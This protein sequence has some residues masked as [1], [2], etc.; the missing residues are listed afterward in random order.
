MAAL[1][2]GGR[3]RVLALALAWWG[4]ELGALLPASVRRGLGLDPDLVVIDAT[5]T[6]IDIGIDRAG[7]LTAIGHATKAEPRDVVAE[8][9]TVAGLVARANGDLERIALR[10]APDQ[11]LLKTIELPLAAEENLRQVLAYEMERQTPFRADQVRFTYAVVGRDA[12]ARRLTVALTVVPNETVERQLGDL[13][14]IGVSPVAVVVGTPGTPLVRTA[15]AT[16]RLRPLPRYRRADRWLAAATVALALILAALPFVRH[17]HATA[18]LDERVARVRAPA[19]AALKLA[20]ELEAELAGTGTVVRIK[21]QAASPVLLIDELARLLP[22]DTWLVQFT[23]SESELEIEGLSLSAAALVAR[24][25]ASRLFA[26]VRFRTPVTRDP[27]T[28][29]E[30]FALMLTVAKP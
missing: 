14:R 18:R 2:I 9:A 30:H 1:L 22:D 15:D 20:A 28:S 6:G 25:E 19:E 8:R 12:A 10:I 27:L 17:E 13:A 21:A 4:A 16:V 29:R 23:L 5:A 3:E 11:A 26:N 7:R 24:L